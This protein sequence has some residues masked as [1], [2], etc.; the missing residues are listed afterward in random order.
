MMKV[1]LLSVLVIL[2]SCSRGQ[3]SNKVD[4]SIDGTK[5]FLV[6]EKS[7]ENLVR[8]SHKE[9]KSN[10]RNFNEYKEF[11]H[12]L[13]E[14]NIASIPL[15]LDYIKTSIDS[16]NTD[17]DSIFLLFNIKFYTITERLNDSLYTKFNYLTVQ[18]QKDSTTQ[19]LNAF[20][21]NLTDCGLAIFQTEGMYYLDVMPDFFYGNFK[22]RVSEGVREFLKIRKDELKQG[23][24]EDAM[25]LISFDDLY[26]R[27]IRWEKFLIQFP[28][29]VY[30]DYA[31]SLYTTYLETLM[32]GMDNSRVFTPDSDILLPDVKVLYEKIIAEK[33]KSSTTRTIE[34]YYNFLSRHDFTENDSI[35]IFL[36]ELNLSTMLAVQPHTR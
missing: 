33:S 9:L 2:L 10:S 4:I 28:N 1:F 15:L 8:E 26:D 24:S 13:D 27:I 6:K 21:N 20:E 25:L 3:E 29:T 35:K 18:L 36:K 16:N 34:S 19:E 11:L 22:D 5:D 31:N 23:F 32:T 14:N 30:T 17:R 12:K 7:I